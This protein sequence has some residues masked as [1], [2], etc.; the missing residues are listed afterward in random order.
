M[1]MF[2]FSCCLA[3]CLVLRFHASRIKCF[4]QNRILFV[5]VCGRC[6]ER[7]ESWGGGSGFDFGGGGRGKKKWSGLQKNCK[8]KA[9]FVA[10]IALNSS[11]FPRAMVNPIFANPH[12]SGFQIF[13][14]PLVWTEV[15]IGRHIL[16]AKCYVPAELAAKFLS[17]D[18]AHLTCV[19][20]PLPLGISC[21]SQFCLSLSAL[22]NIGLNSKQS[23]GISW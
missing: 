3:S 5:P 8:E 22:L 13:L 6:L 9:S 1:N 20:W 4:I 7:W 2:L 15:E 14:Q 19:C 16:P 11:N 21:F 10:L 23:R 17:N 18:A 12:L